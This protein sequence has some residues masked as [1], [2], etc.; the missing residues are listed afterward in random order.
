MLLY[1]LYFNLY[2]KFLFILSKE[3]IK[4]VVLNTASMDIKC[5]F[6]DHGQFLKFDKGIQIYREGE[7]ASEI[8]L[9]KHGKVQISKETES[10]KELTFRICGRGSILGETTLFSKENVHTTSAIALSPSEVLMLTKDSLEMLLTE[11][12]ALLIEYLR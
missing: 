6:E 7:F 12:P 3:V 4:L 5:L 2:Y 11:Q 9:L 8:F 1:V 10:G